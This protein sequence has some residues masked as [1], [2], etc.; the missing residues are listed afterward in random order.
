MIEAV[1]AAVSA[2]AA[3]IA[4]YAAWAAG[5]KSELRREDVLQWSISVIEALEELYILCIRGTEIVS[6]EEFSKRMSNVIFA[7]GSM[8]ETGRLFF[9]NAVTDDFG[10]EKYP[11]YRG[12][13]PKILDPIVVAHQIACQWS[14]SD[15]PTRRKMTIV[16]EDCL[17]KF[18]ALAQMEVG[19]SRTA[20]ADTGKG[21]DGY[22]LKYLLT[23][24]SEGKLNT[25]KTI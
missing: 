15:E 12:Y 16:A 21:G 11:P 20:S 18:V 2:V 5:R 17:K 4:L 14:T 23:R 7:T 10:K 19:R 3:V 13:R 25:P 8:T 9:K 22:H 24:V 6:R 1:A